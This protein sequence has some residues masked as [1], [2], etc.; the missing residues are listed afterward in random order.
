V[1]SKLEKVFAF[2]CKIFFVRYKGIKRLQ[3]DTN[4]LE[5]ATSNLL[6]FAKR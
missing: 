3:G 1:V 6:Y 5:L 2:L 4:L